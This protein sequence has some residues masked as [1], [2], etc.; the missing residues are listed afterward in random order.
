MRVLVQ[1]F[2]EVTEPGGSRLKKGV[3]RIGQSAKVAE[4]GTRNHQPIT[5]L[6]HSCPQLFGTSSPRRVVL[7]PG[8]HIAEVR[9]PRTFRLVTWHVTTQFLTIL[10]TQRIPIYISPSIP[11]AN[12][13]LDPFKVARNFRWQT[14]SGAEYCQFSSS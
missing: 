14:E 12:L 5:N 11:S 3:W 9:N 7:P 1:P 6:V 8:C 2:L 4:S 10:M 13:P